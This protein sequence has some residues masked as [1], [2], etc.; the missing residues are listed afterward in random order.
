MSAR[1]DV[2]ADRTRLVATWIAI[3]SLVATVVAIVWGRKLAPPRPTARDSFSSG[4]LGHKAFFETLAALRFPIVRW[5][6]GDP[7]EVPGTLFI[8]EPDAAYVEV[9]G[10]ELDLAELVDARI[11]AGRRTVV[12]LPKWRTTSLGYAEV[13]DPALADELLESVWPGAS[14]VHHGAP[15]ATPTSFTGRGERVHAVDLS[16]PFPATIDGGDRP[17]LEVDRGRVVISDAKRLI[18]V[19]ADPDLVHNFNVQRAHHAL[20]WSRFVRE[21]LGGGALVLDETFH[22]H[23]R[24]RSIAEALGEWPGVLLLGQMFLVGIV[25]LLMN[26]VRFGKP[27]AAAAA[28]GRG[29]REAISVSAL[30]LGTG[31]PL[32][33]L[34]VA[35]VEHAVDDLHR[36]LG[37]P[38]ATSVE[39]KATAI[40][41]V[42]VRRGL[43]RDAEAALATARAARAE[44][45]AAQQAYAAARRIH[46]HRQV[47][48]GQRPGAQS[49]EGT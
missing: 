11:A 18:F 5:Q 28:H 49:S 12:V 21:E 37:L 19:V 33:R 46:A 43:A 16:L 3:L 42:A 35:Y 40:D 9:D 26:R 29:P 15:E 25:I 45:R 34:G 6:Q 44:R 2:F 20:F 4:P 38:D 48:L 31:Q 22:G 30:V 10:L 17:V 14:L 27:M 24:T 41:D 13:E 8:V 7:T 32:G 23:R 1:D 39:A 36:R 47:L